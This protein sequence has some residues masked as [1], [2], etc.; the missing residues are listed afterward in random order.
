MHLL[1]NDGDIAGYKKVGA[2][3]MLNFDLLLV[4][5]SRAWLSS[6]AK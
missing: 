1:E 6:V 3:M 5:K 2:G 4:Y